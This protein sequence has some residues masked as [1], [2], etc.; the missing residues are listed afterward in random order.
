MKTIEERARELVAKYGEIDIFHCDPNPSSPVRIWGHDGWDSTPFQ[1]AGISVMK[2][3]QWLHERGGC[4]PYIAQVY[5]GTTPSVY[6]VEFADAGNPVAVRS[7]RRKLVR[8]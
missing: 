4:S 8:S 6:D 2:M 5:L 1:R 7:A 3:A